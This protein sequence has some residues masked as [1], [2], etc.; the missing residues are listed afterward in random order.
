MRHVGDRMSEAE[1]M[2][3][4]FWD[5]GY[6]DLLPVTPP[7]AQLHPESSL[8]E[9][10]LGK[11]PGNRGQDGLWTGRHYTKT[12][13]HESD[14]DAWY[15]WGAGVGIRGGHD[16]FFV[17]VDHMDKAK[18]KR[19]YD[20]AV[21][22]LGRVAAVQGQPP[23]FALPYRSATHI[24]S[25]NIKF[26]VPMIAGKY[27]G[28]DIISDRPHKVVAGVHKGSGKAYRWVGGIPA[29][30]DLPL[31]TQPMFDA[32]LRAVEA[33]FPFRSGNDATDKGDREP[34][35]PESLRA[36]SMEAL[37]KAVEATPNTP[38]MFPD[39]NE[40]Y[41]PFMQAIKGAAGPDNDDDA[42]EVFH[43]WA[44]RWP[45][46][47]EGVIEADWRKAHDSHSIGWNYVQKHAVGLY[48]E[49]VV[50]SD[51]DM[52]FEA[53]KADTQ[54]R[55]KLRIELLT[56]EQL[57]KM[58]NPRWLIGRHI[59]ETGFG[60]LFG[61]PGT[62]KSFLAL[63]MGLSI[64]AWFKDWYG[65]PIA[66]DAGA[67]LYIA[68]E[69]AGA[70]KL[71]IQAWK[72]QNWVEGEMIPADR[73][74]VV[75]AALNFM[76]HEDIAE[77]LA[78]VDASGLKRIALIIIDTVSRAIPGAD[79]NKQQ[80]MSIFVKACDTLRDRTGA[81]ILGIHHAAK[82]GDM[83]GSSVI[84]GGGDAIFRV[85]RKKGQNYVRL[86]CTKQKDAPDQWHNS[87]RLNLVNLGGDVSSLAPVRVEEKEVEEAICTDEIKEQIF[88][89]IT[90]DAADANHWSMAPQAKAARRKYAPDEVSRG[91]G[92]G[93]E[94]A[95]QWL[96]M[97]LSGPEP[98]LRD[99]V[100]HG[101]SK[102]R[103]LTV[104]DKPIMDSVFS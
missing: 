62:Y 51:A 35:D 85:E 87:Y 95:K 44:M 66:E 13:T 19:L 38:E 5:L 104:I 12:S 101:N 83:R 63:D 100:V 16:L 43:E 49:P 65:D 89:A 73:F 1:N 97:W 61:D 23:K 55:P 11:S 10:D 78:V 15:A 31:V 17:D 53:V 41:I 93:Q 72:K 14:C 92:V 7:N 48:F 60:I 54:S 52:M 34:V 22:H 25:R 86:T 28:I 2:F 91:W 102:R 18:A 82:S 27:P 69:G 24:R 3:R 68:G 45:G 70:F 103:G 99:A 29:K 67:V 46:A 58:P 81:F 8:S 74:R 33:E 84:P 20:L 59:P 6:R 88:A 4:K 71:R 47:D 94:V 77:L 64:A 26:D 80:D 79:E 98:E 21:E 9:K 39:R 76:R 50:P 40:H 42:Y 32:F 30:D 75:T 96:E 90:R 36:P 57:Q 37:R 56:D